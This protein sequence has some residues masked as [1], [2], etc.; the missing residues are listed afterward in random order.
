M[1]VVHRPP[2]RRLWV[3]N[4]PDRIK[5]L[6]RVAE[7]AASIDAMKRFEAEASKAK[8]ADNMESSKSYAPAGIEKLRKDET[9][10]WLRD[11][12]KEDWDRDLWNTRDPYVKAMRQQAEA[13][14]PEARRVSR[15][16]RERPPPPNPVPDL[17]STSP[18]LPAPLFVF[19]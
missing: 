4:D 2:P 6:Q 17:M 9:E 8:A 12:A 19:Q 10:V 16:Y 5:R 14:R 7:L 3:A 1:E 13:P 15:D 18:S 11:E